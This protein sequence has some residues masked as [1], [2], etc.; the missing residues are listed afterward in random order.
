MT[1]DRILTLTATSGTRYSVDAWESTSTTP[2]SRKWQYPARIKRLDDG[3]R[4]DRWETSQDFRNAYAEMDSHL[5]VAV[6]GLKRLLFEHG[7]QP[8]ELVV[9]RN[10]DV[11]A[12]ALRRE[13]ELDCSVTSSR[14]R[15]LRN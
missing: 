8:D 4:L 14:N 2:M 6:E 15:S 5:D 12:T 10:A 1:H 3:Y 7:V 9:S 13:I 11:T